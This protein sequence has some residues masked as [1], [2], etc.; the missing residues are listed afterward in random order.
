MRCNTARMVRTGLVLALLGLGAGADAQQPGDVAIHGFGGW[1][2]GHSSNDNRYGAITGGNWALDNYYF[3]L[4]LSAQPQE[5]LEIHAQ[6]RWRTN[7]DGQSLGVDYL[8]VQYSF[9]NRAAVRVGKVKNPLGLYTEILDVGTLRPFYLLSQ[10][11][12]DGTAPSYV[13]VGGVGRVPVGKWELELDGF[14]GQQNYEPISMELPVGVD[15]VT[16]VPI[17]ASVRIHSEGREMFG[18]RANLHTPVPG[19]MVGMSGS[20]SRIYSGLAGQELREEVDERLTLLS[21][22][23]EFAR[24]RFT[25]RAEAFQASGRTEFSAWYAELSCRPTPQIELAATYEW[26]DRTKLGDLPLEQLGEHKAVGLGFNYWP[27]PRLVFKLDYYHVIGN[28]LAR[29]ASAIEATLTGT[30]QDSTDVVIVGTQF[31]F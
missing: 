12:Y 17:L 7:A 21:G 3:A 27:D 25:L 6:P 24:D 20:S 10:A 13:G 9:S 18:G 30:L 11:R 1:A 14:A 22:H 29:P 15:P 19:L 28:A 4:N 31:S 16:S 26:L 5:K 8:F 2:A 23:V